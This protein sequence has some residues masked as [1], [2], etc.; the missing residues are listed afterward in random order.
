MAGSRRLRLAVFGAV[1]AALLSVAAV[2]LVF[3]RAEDDIYLR[4]SL[5]GAPPEIDAEGFVVTSPAS[6]DVVSTPATTLA[7]I[8]PAEPVR[9]NPGPAARSGQQVTTPPAQSGAFIAD[10]SYHARLTP[11]SGYGGGTARLEIRAGRMHLSVDYEGAPPGARIVQ[12][13]VEDCWAG[14]I[15][16]ADGGLSVP[17][18]L[19]P[20]GD[21]FGTADAAG[22]VE[23]RASRTIADLDSGLRG[24]SVLSRYKA[25]GVGSFQPGRSAIM[26]HAGD[27]SRRISCARFEPAS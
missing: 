4:A 2:W 26:L 9:A 18:E 21:H 13:I 23:L 20:R 3:G 24:Y 6:F 5:G 17:G 7:P 8:R 14:I 15:I 10:G 22:K 11:V 19:P 16:N 25:G 12:H 1:A 27:W